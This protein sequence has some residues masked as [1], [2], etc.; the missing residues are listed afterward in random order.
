[1]PTTHLIGLLLGVEEDWPTAFE[2]LL[3]RA[4]VIVRSGGETHRFDTERI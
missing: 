1:M 4:D 3:Q 2:S